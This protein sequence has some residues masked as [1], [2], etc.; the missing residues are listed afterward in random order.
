MSR[1]LR[2][3]ASAVLLAMGSRT[4]WAQR[5][6]SLEA[7]Q[8]EARRQAPDRGALD[9][10]VQAAEA[11]AQPAGRVWRIDPEL[12]ASVF[13]GQ[14]TGRPD[15]SAWSVG[16]RWTVDLSRSWVPRAAAAASDVTRAQFDRDDGLRMLDERVAIAFAEV[17]LAQRL[18]ERTARLRGLQATVADAEHRRLDVGDGTQLEADAADLDLAGARAAEEQVKGDLAVAQLRLARLLGRRDA[19]TLIVEDRPEPNDAPVAPDVG[20]LTDRD[21]RVR[22]ADA[23]VQAARFERQVSER[24]MRP[25]PTFGVDAGTQRREIPLGSFTGQ[26]FTPTLSARWRDPEVSFSVTVPIPLFDRQR[27]ARARATARILEAEAQLAVVR[28][29]VRNELQAAWEQ[30][31]AAQRAWQAVAATTAMIDR[32]TTFVEQA[33]RA[34]AFDAVTRTQTLRRLE[35]A[36]RRVDSALRDVR[37]ARA[38]WVRRTAELLPLR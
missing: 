34:G 31:Q 38:T 16:A 17:A 35:E 6:L 12:S 8:E 20:A 10:H 1:A 33:V 32:D 11:V 5:P 9:A 18:V 27:E 4:V 36:G 30:L 2:T 24:L 25:M 14:V 28:S 29:M 26:P 21:P 19:G 22:A 3:F 37:A 23:E 7:A 13:P 15:E